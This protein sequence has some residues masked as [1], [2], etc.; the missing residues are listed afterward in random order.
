VIILGT[1]LAQFF[2]TGFE[3]RQSCRGQ[4]VKCMENFMK[5]IDSELPVFMSMSINP[6]FEIPFDDREVSTLWLRTFP[7]FMTPYPYTTTCWWWMSA[8]QIF[9]FMFKDQVTECTPQLTEVVI[10]IVLYKVLWHRNQ[11]T[12]WLNRTLGMWQRVWQ[13]LTFKT[14]SQWPLQAGFTSKMA[15]IKCMFL[16]YLQ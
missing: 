4:I 3:L 8:G 15:L 11:F 10:Q 5:L 9:L 16:L 7:L 14:S 2:C 12:Q 1:H 6:V 13:L